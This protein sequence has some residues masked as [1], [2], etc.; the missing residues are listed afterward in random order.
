MKKAKKTFIYMPKYGCY[1]N[2]DDIIR[3][4]KDNDGS[5]VLLLNTPGKYYINDNYYKKIEELIR[6]NN[7]VIDL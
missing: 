7:N 6:K 1:I 2:L 4:S 5:Y 3:L